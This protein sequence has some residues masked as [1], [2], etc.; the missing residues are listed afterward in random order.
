VKTKERETN[1]LAESRKC[2]H[3]R[4][5]QIK[6]ELA[7]QSGRVFGNK[8]A[9]EGSG[10][11]TGQKNIKGTPEHSHIGTVPGRH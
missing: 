11:G 2:W 7:R 1:I 10:S 6:R 3:T 8:N 9:Q 5:S 4:I